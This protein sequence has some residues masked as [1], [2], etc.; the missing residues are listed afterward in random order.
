MTLMI[1]SIEPARSRNGSNGR[2]ANYAQKHTLT[3]SCLYIAGYLIQKKHNF[4]ERINQKYRQQR[5][6][7]KL[8]MLSDSSLL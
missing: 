4:T 1:V 3:N 8:F 2:R 6:G 7:N 5:Y